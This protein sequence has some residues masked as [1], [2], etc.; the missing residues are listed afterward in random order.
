[1]FKANGKNCSLL[2]QLQQE[3]DSPRLFG[4]DP[5]VRYFPPTTTTPAPIDEKADVED[6]DDDVCFGPITF[7]ELR[8][9]SVLVKNRCEIWSSL[10]YCHN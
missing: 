10:S 9:A 7:K 3:S 4:V 5:I 8:K 1:M 6:S 2:G